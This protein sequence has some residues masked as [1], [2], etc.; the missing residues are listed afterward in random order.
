MLRTIFEHATRKGMLAENPAKGARK[1]SDKRRTLRLSL[2]QVRSLGMAM[3]EAGASGE[4]STGLAA[5]RA[6]LL[7]GFRREEALSIRGHWLLQSGGV[8][9]PDTKSGPQV[10]PIGRAAMA[11]LQQQAASAGR[12]KTD[13]LFPGDRG[14][15]HFVGIR[16]VLARVC[17]RTNLTGVTPHV[18]R[19]SFASIA[20]DLGYSELVIAGLLGHAAGS[21]TSGYVHLDSALVAA[22]DR[23]AG[24]IADALD[25]KQDAVVVRIRSD[26]SPIV[27]AAK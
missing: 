7:T 14:D 5:I 3:Q 8:D 6:I 16:K 24:V 1:F 27:A 22:A 13:W 21:V 9:F 12:A 15:G 25:G 11:E 26:A 18:L 19:H 17:A 4:N 20:G 10:R 2:D 23:V